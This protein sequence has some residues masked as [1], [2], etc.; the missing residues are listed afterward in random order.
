MN[1]LIPK[2]LLPYSPIKAECNRVFFNFRL[3]LIVSATQ[4]SIQ[5]LFKI[6]Q[7]MYSGLWEVTGNGN[8]I[9]TYCL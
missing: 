9:C 4:S 6:F 7:S 5:T 8:L 1:V 2:L 3:T